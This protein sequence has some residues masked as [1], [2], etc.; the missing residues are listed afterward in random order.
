MVQIATWNDWGEGTG[1]EPT[2]EFGNRD[3]LTIQRLRPGRGRTPAALA[4]LSRISALLRA[5]KAREAS[6]AME[7]V[8]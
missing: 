2:V 7:A 6:A 5:G 3:L 8:R 1:I 4:K